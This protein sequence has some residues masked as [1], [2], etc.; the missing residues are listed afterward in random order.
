MFTERIRSRTVFGKIYSQMLCQLRIIKLCKPQSN[1]F[2]S[3]RNML[4]SHPLNKHKFVFKCKYH[5][6][7]RMWETHPKIESPAWQNDVRGKTL[8]KL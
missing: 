6:M 3:V 2:S 5:N 7:Q 8:C 4:I 1:T